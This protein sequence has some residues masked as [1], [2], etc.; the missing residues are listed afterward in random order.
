[1]QTS[2]QQR[3]ALYERLRSGP[4]FSGWHW[5]QWN[6][7]DHPQGETYF[8]RLTLNVL[9]HCDAAMPGYADEM[10]GRLESLGGKEK[11]F[12]DYEAIRQWLGELVVVGHFVAWDWPASVSFRHEPVAT[13]SSRN[14]EI[15]VNGGTFR[16]GVEVKTPNLSSFARTRSHRDWQ[17]LV[18]VHGDPTGLPGTVTLPRDN[19][20]K[21]F[22]ISA[23]AKF[24]AFRATDP[25]FRSVL[26]IVWDD[27]V[28]EPISAL[29]SPG[30][31]LLTPS[32]FD[33]LP[34]GTRRRYPNVDAIVLL[35]H[36]HQLQEGMANR[37]PLDDRDHFL[38]YGSP[39]RFPPNA[40][41][42]CPDGRALNQPLLDA[43]CAAPIAPHLGAE[44]LPGD[45]VMWV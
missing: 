34:D 16:L 28:N 31:G 22:L 10:L 9:L 33:T 2:E 41:I 39:D 15:V 5:L 40:L 44:Y 14:P 26:V 25:A 18:R 1:M 7:A 11:D 6:F 17:L 24:A 37:P 20:L 21:D 43:L 13:G 19:P 35:R 27:Y 42:P 8:A 3:L 36:Q 23:D 38:D 32:S 4:M 29:L 30:S 45:W 12:K